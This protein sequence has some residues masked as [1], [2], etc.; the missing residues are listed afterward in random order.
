MENHDVSSPIAR[1]LRASAIVCLVALFP[2]CGGS[3]DTPGTAF[4]T[5][6]GVPDSAGHTPFDVFKT[7]VMAANK[8]DYA[9]AKANIIRN[10]MMGTAFTGVDVLPQKWPPYTRNGTVSSIDF[11]S[12]DYSMG[13]AH[14]HYVL[15]F[16][17]GSTFKERATLVKEDDHWKLTF[18]TENEP[19]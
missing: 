14:V 15:H 11:V 2:A 18:M 1:C 3:S 10:S 17:D 4:E 9:T 8:G 13:E 12:D 7:A 6:N 5:K 19:F 16:Q